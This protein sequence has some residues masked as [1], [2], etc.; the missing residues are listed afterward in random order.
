MVCFLSFC[1]FRCIENGCL[2]AAFW[3]FEWWGKEAL[4]LDPAVITIL[5]RMRTLSTLHLPHFTNYRII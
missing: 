4:A 2:P 1:V 3:G 5:T